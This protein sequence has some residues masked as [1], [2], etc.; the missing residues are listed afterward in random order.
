MVN[1]GFGDSLG[2][3]VQGNL[4]HPP[5]SHRFLPEISESP[6]SEMLMHLVPSVL[7]LFFAKGGQL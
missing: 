1:I 3:K 4:K 5:G 6:D 7:T 2:L